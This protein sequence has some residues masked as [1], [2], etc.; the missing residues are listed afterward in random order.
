MAP[1][2]NAIIQPEELLGL[3]AYTRMDVV[4]PPRAE[5]IVQINNVPRTFDVQAV[6]R[7]LESSRGPFQG[8]ISSVGM[9]PE[10]RVFPNVND[11]LALEGRHQRPQGILRVTALTVSGTERISYNGGGGGRGG[12][13]CSV[14]G[15]CGGGGGGWRGGGGG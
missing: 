3:I 14:W 8:S 6:M 2:E 13:E 11:Q 10:R 1:L 7:L 5:Y 4:A 15:G 9:T 12:K